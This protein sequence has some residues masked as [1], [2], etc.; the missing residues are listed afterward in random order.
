[1]GWDASVWGCGMWGCHHRDVWGLLVVCQYASVGQGACRA[2]WGHEH[3]WGM[4]VGPGTHQE[5][6]EGMGWAWEHVGEG[7][8][9]SMAVGDGDMCERG[10][11]M[12][13]VTWVH[14]GG[15]H[16][17]SLRARACSMV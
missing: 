11:S 16:W 13:G 17:G 10:Q 15:V 12:H 7:S 8:N 6:P 4:K 3:G 9:M 14:T 5:E 1:M 2:T